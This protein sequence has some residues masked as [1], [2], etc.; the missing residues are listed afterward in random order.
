[1]YIITQ[2]KI[3]QITTL[4]HYSENINAYTEALDLNEKNQ[5]GENGNLS[6]NYTVLHFFQEYKCAAIH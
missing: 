1:M 4:E 3:T 5:W 2:H 6:E